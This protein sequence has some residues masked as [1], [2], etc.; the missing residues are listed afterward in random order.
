M[1]FPG[2]DLAA[3]YETLRRE[4]LAEQAGSL[5]RGIIM[6]LGVARWMAQQTSREELSVPALP[7]LSA[8]E[9][10]GAGLSNLSSQLATLLCAWLAHHPLAVG[11][12]S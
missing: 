2:K 8:R 7:D 10:S 4:V 3:Q 5:E 9:R 1:I 6:T 12:T 11:E